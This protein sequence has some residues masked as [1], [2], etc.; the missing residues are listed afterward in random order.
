VLTLI[1]GVPPAETC[2]V[3]ETHTLMI[4]SNAAMAAG[5]VRQKDCVLVSTMATIAANYT[6][7]NAEY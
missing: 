4:T 5:G 7:D 6:S 3:S 1:V 2:D